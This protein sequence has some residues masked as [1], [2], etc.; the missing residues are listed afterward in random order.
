MQLPLVTR[1][2]EAK[3]WRRFFLLVTGLVPRLSSVTISARRRRRPSDYDFM[4]LSPSATRLYDDEEELK[5][6]RGSTSSPYSSHPLGGEIFVRISISSILYI[7][8]SDD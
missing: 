3:T 2:P 8:I 7:S 6:R 4:I 5:K 1:S